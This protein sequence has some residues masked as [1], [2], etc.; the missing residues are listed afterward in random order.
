MDNE[1][2]CF[3]GSDKAELMYP[4]TD[5]IVCIE[6]G[7]VFFKG[8]HKPVERLKGKSN[9]NSYKAL[10]EQIDELKKDMKMFKA[11]KGKVSI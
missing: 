2:G 10:K 1:F 5:F 8:K 7:L 3:C 6:C 9:G 4:L 11:L